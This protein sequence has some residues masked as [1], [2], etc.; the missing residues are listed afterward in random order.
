MAHVVMQCAQL[1]T[2]AAA[3]S[4]AQALA[5]LIDEYSAWE[6]AAGASAWDE[7]PL[8]PPLHAFADRHGFVWP[9]GAR[10]LL[11]G[12]AGE[13]LQVAAIDE[14]V[15]FWGGGF[16]VGG[17][18]IERFFAAVGAVAQAT[19][20]HLKVRSESPAALVESLARF[21]D[22]E[23]Y[24]EQYSVQPLADADLGTLLHSVTIEGPEP[25]VLG[26]D[27]SGVQDWAFTAVLHQLAGM[28]PRLG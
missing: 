16:E 17:A 4:V 10:N 19:C 23:D 24:E 7:G 6:D 18:G 22:D 28:H 3:E 1:P 20:C 9:D 27:D 5:R 15:F 8:P 25:V 21:L 26:F 2:A 13:V 14:L 11:E 12:M